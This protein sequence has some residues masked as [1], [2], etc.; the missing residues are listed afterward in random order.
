MKMWKSGRGGVYPFF[1]ADR[2]QTWRIP[3]EGVM[4]EKQNIRRLACENK[5]H[6]FNLH[7]IRG[8]VELSCESSPV[9]PTRPVA[10]I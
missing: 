8:G 10:E 1:G 2:G 9:V 4:S 5:K 6:A 7:I 3:H